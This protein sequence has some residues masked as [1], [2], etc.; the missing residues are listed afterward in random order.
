MTTEFVMDASA[1]LALIY[2]ESGHD[3]VAAA[4]PNSRICAVNLAEIVSSMIDEEIPLY[5]IERRMGRLLSKV[6]DLDRDLA[7]K[8]GLLRE[9]TRHKGLSLGDRACL[10]LAMRE[11]LPVMTADRAWRDLDLPVEVVLI[12]EP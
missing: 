5:D 10:A 7:M 8:A 6:V 9:A 11:R 3:R 1:I 2:G 4:L 12:R